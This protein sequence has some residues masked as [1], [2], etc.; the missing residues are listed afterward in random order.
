MK[1]GSE[2]TRAYSQSAITNQKSAIFI[3]CA[4]QTPLGDIWL[5]VTERGLAAVEIQ[6]EREAFIRELK[7][8]GFEDVI[9]DP[10]QV[11]QAAQQ[12]S[13]YLEGKRRDFDLPIDWTGMGGFQQ[14]ALRLVWAVP[15]GQVATY[16]EIA[17]QLGKPQAGRAVGRANATNPMPLVIPCH[18]LVGADGKLHGYGAP[19][20]IETKAWLLKLE[21]S[22]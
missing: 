7:R 19:G 20:G 14:T 1:I 16:G 5:A 15:Y 10:Q 6:S 4:S 18:R 11:E 3:G 17:R 12:V 21:G 9:E 2:M 8:R 22:R 13:E